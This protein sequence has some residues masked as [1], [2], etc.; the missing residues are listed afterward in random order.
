M[1]F[2]LFS[3]ALILAGCGDKTV[4]VR[5]AIPEVVITSPASGY[6]AAEGEELTVEGY[7]GDADDSAETLS[8]RWTVDGDEV[9]TAAPESDGTTSCTFK[10]EAGDSEVQLVVVD[11]SGALRLA[12][13]QPD[14]ATDG[15]GLVT[16]L[17]LP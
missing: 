9:C 7:A 12:L 15:C 5:N 2:G 10:V 8:A 14:G 17:T 11:P 1:K 4:S 16:V 3:A 13:G 6:V